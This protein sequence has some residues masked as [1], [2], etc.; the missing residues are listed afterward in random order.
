MQE[1][2]ERWKE[3][4]VKKKAVF[5]LVRL[6]GAVVLLMIVKCLLEWV[7]GW[8]EKRLKQRKGC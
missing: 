8:W 2:G 3:R 5:I 7:R 1:M 6:K 4:V